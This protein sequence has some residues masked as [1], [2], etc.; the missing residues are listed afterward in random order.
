MKVRVPIFYKS[1]RCKASAC[2]DTCCAGW[3][4]DVDADSMQR[5]AK[6]QGSF[7][8]KLR[9]QIVDGHFALDE[10][11]RCPFLNSKNLCEIY[12]HL[13]ENS[14]C[15]ICREHPRFVDVF[16]DEKEQGV[17]LC[18]EEAVQL[19]LN[20]EGPL[21]FE[22][23]V[24]SEAPEV[25]DE[26]SLDAKNSIFA[27]RTEIFERLSN[28]N[29][30][31][32]ECLADILRFTAGFSEETTDIAI[33]N[34]D[35]IWNHQVKI[36]MQ[37]E[38][39]GAEWNFAQAQIE[40]SLQNTSFKNSSH[41]FSDSDGEKL[42][43]YQI[44]RYFAKSLYDGD[45]LSKVKFAIFFWL[46]LQNYGRELSLFKTKPSAAICAVKLLSKQIEYSDENMQRLA[47]AFAA[48]TYFSTG[49][50]LRLLGEN[51]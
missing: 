34:A 38:S 13:G 44:F 26:E 6:V 11:E 21:T 20:L 24:D 47:D 17:G 45:M 27:I 9:S 18:C 23:L 31:L 46:L 41:L 42:V 33:E 15:D 19:L 1:F 28:R 29:I 40:A 2:E 5:Y 30:S 3:E 22:E 48:D 49:A 7:G 43:A 51:T 50:F 4:V 32:W 25:L 16:G 35:E 36:L 37:G 39:L 8:E 10:K 12:L 14:L